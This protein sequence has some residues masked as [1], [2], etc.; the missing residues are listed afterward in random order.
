MREK[1]QYKPGHFDST[2]YLISQSNDWEPVRMRDVVEYCSINDTNR[3]NFLGECIL[4]GKVRSYCEGVDAEE[5]TPDEL[6]A[7]ATKK[8]A[9]YKEHWHRIFLQIVRYNNPTVANADCYSMS[10]VLEH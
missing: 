6:D 4:E 1:W 8:F 2:P 3:P 5:M 10:Q 9:F 7:V